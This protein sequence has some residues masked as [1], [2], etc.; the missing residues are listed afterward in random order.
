VA[1]HEALYE[2]PPCRLRALQVGRLSV[3]AD[4]R[5]T[6]VTIPILSYL[7][8]APGGLF[9]VDC[10]LSARWA[11]G[12]QVHLGP[13]DSPSPG[14]P[15]MPELDG[16][17]MSSQLAT[18]DLHPQRLVCTHL[19]EDHAGG[20][21]ELGLT[22]EASA[23]ELRRLAEADAAALGYP[24]D[25]L[26]GV[27]TR[28]IELDANRPLGPFPATAQLAEGVLAVDTSGHTPGHI[29]V[30]ACIGLAF[31]LICGDAVYPRLDQPGSPAFIGALRI[32]RAID[33]IPGLQLFPAHDTVVL[34]SGA[35][36]GW[37]GG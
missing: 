26:A 12:G 27:A 13:E 17:G 18:L 11:G 30:L 25:D 15:Y 28:A 3:I 31:A 24:V 1:S 14:T 36:E 32:R 9:A 22:L 16:P 10:G 29:S 34:R 2:L 23:A 5:R 19:H 33:E 20:A 35:A 7:L 4:G 6:G 8:D 37:L 21:A